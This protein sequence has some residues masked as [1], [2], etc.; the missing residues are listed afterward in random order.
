MVIVFH[1]KD[2]QEAGK[3]KHQENYVIKIIARNMNNEK[4][5]NYINRICLYHIH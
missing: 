3:L 2:L 5:K 4:Y 1:D